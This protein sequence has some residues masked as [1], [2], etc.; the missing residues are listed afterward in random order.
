MRLAPK[1]LEILACLSALAA[2][3]S[4]ARHYEGPR[5]QGR[6][7]AQWFHRW[8]EA[9][10]REGVQARGQE[11]E[12]RYAIKQIGT[13][14]LPFLLS[15]LRVEAEKHAAPEIPP[16]CVFAIL[17]PVASPAVP[18]LEAMM[19]ETNASL[20][21]VA[22][23]C[24]AVIGDEAVPSLT[25]LL[26]APQGSTRYETAHQLCSQ[27]A[28]QDGAFTQGTHLLQ[29]IPPLVTCTRDPDPYVAIA[30][31]Q[32]LSYI[33]LEPDTTIPAIRSALQSPSNQVREEAAAALAK[34]AR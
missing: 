5:Y 22:A 6:S 1:A 8:A 17:G 24:L 34:I 9:T 23:Y 26:S 13:N 18:E 25:R 28:L 30:A 19:R 16:N 2:I 31:I 4:C 11:E 27:L 33:N 7:F 10:E 15:E 21:R 3:A 14:V 32:S 29:L 12:A 20:H